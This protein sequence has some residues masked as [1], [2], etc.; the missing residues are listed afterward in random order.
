[1]LI[2]G[3]HTI[4]YYKVTTASRGGTKD[5]YAVAMVAGMKAMHGQTAWDTSFQCHC[6]M[7]SLLRAESDAEL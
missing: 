1:M 7:P 3:L 5:R 2:S 6:R 4:A